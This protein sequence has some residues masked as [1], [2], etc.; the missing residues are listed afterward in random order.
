MEVKAYCEKKQV[1]V[2]EPSV[3]CGSCH[4]LPF[5]NVNND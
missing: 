1:Q 2:L 5:V 3:G 4:D